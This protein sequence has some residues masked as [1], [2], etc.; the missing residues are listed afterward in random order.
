[1][2]SI[3]TRRTLPGTQ[4]PCNGLHQNWKESTKDS[5]TLQWT[6]EIIKY[7]WM[8]SIQGLNHVTMDFTITLIV[9]WMD[10]TRAIYSLGRKWIDHLKLDHFVES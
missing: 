3:K 8:H 9:Q 4:S 2:D 1:M 10:F 5:I 6:Q 7:Q